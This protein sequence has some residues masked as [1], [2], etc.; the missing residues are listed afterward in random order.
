MKLFCVAISSLFTCFAQAAP[1]PIPIQA[2]SAILINGHTGK[3]IFEKNS[4]KKQY[5]ASLT[6]IAT[7]IYAIEKESHGLDLMMTP[8]QDAL[9][10]I[11]ATEK[12]RDNYSRYPSHWLE[13]DACHMGIKRDEQLA[14]KDLLYG[15]MIAS[16]DDAA[17]IIAQ[18]VGNGSISQFIKELNQFLH[19]IGCHN[20][21]FHN[22]HGLFHP[23]HMSTCADIARLSQYA[24]K[25]ELFR[26]IVKTVRYERPT[27]NKQEKS[28][29]LQLNKLLRFGGRW[30]YKYAV[31][32]KTGYIAKA[33]HNLACAAVKDG[34][35]LIAVY[36]YCSDRD[37]MFQQARAAFDQAFAQKA[38]ERVVA[39][40]GQQPFQRKVD[41]AFSYLK[42]SIAKPLVVRYFPAEEPEIRCQLI[43]DKVELP[44]IAG[45]KVGD[46]MLL[47]DN[48]CVEKAPLV[49]AYD[50]DKSLLSSICDYLS[51]RTG[52]MCLLVSIGLTLFIWAKRYKTTK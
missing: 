26:D 44:I 11:S 49:A 21:H 52:V 10:W 41:G 31:G 40:S 37:Q 15:L 9:G 20:T 17:N 5:P 51:S 39:A 46:L 50:L 34:R 8:S 33:K 7:A 24:M 25:N 28:M 19:S 30:Y 12:S 43:W 13:T 42:T 6:K 29:M 4:E 23:N 27:T 16:A 2:D 36:M 35:L 32:I 18:H 48:V 3:V 47:V 45:D 14:F 1:F 22:P 38:V